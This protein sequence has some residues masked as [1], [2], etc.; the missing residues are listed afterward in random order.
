MEFINSVL[1]LDYQGW[2]KTINQ[3]LLYKYFKEKAEEEN[4]KVKQK[5]ATYN[6]ITNKTPEQIEEYIKLLDQLFENSTNIYKKV[7]EN[8]ENQELLEELYSNKNIDVSEASYKR[9]LETG[10]KIK[11]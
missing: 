10:E 5:M 2:K 6:E 11:L 9:W 8:L 1:N 3:I 7:Q 4:E